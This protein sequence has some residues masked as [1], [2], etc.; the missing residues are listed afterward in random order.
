VP[1]EAPPPAP[2]VLEVAASEVTEFELL[3]SSEAA[4]QDSFQDMVTFPPDDLLVT[5][6]PKVHRT[7]QAVKMVGIAFALLPIH[8]FLRRMDQS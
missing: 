8:T 4:L 6:L 7:S 5:T 2:P 3:C 1:P